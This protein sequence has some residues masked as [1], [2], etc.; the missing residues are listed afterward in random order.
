[1]NKIKSKSE[2]IEGS[3]RRGSK[4][5]ALRDIRSG[6]GGV[7]R[8]SCGPPLWRRRWRRSR[9][10]R[11]RWSRTKSRADRSVQPIR[12]PIPRSF[13]RWRRTAPRWPLGRCRTRPSRP[14]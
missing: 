3:Y 1:M 8:R 6:A 9:P 7:R 10:V 14:G 5:S 2:V 12:A 11:C 4:W 13:P